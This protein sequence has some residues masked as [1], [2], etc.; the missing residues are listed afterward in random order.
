[1][2]GYSI[3]KGNKLYRKHQ[4][5]VITWVDPRRTS[6][7][8]NWITTVFKNSVSDDIF[9]ALKSRKNKSLCLSSSFM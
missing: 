1:M 4:L 7:Y 8:L 6:V 2:F 3:Q 5:D 9:I